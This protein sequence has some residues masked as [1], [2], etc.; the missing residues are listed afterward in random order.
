LIKP[1]LLFW[2][3]AIRVATHSNLNEQT[4]LRP[5]NMAD[6]ESHRPPLASPPEFNSEEDVTTVKLDALKA[7]LPS[8]GIKVDFPGEPVEARPQLAGHLLVVP[9]FSPMTSP[10][11]I[12][13]GQHLQAK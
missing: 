4:V 5:P 1:Q 11:H 8:P 10:S 3:L 9:L 6:D 7:D 2:L 13:L 12:S